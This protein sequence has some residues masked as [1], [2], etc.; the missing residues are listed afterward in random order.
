M[1]RELNV[2][3][4]EKEGEKFIFFYD[5]ESFAVLLQTLGNFAADPNSG[6]TW[7]DAA[8]LTQRARQLSRGKD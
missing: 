3:A 1:R 2:L 5:D 7:Y 6:F 8:V 4:L